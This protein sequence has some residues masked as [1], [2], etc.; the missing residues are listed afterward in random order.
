MSTEVAPVNRADSGFRLAWVVMFGAPLLWAILTLVHPSGEGEISA[1]LQ[2]EVGRWLFVHVAQVVLAPFLALAVWLLLRGIES[3]AATIS[4]VALVFWLVFFSTYDALAG[5]ASGVLVRQANSV[6]GEERA[7]FS[8]AADVLFDS[9]I[10]GNIS[11]FGV[12]AAVTWVIVAIAAA[13]ALRGAG[14]NWLTTAA[15]ALSALFAFH[16]G[17]PAFIGLIALLVAAFLWERRRA[18]SPVAPP[19]AAPAP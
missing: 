3:L 2:D 6:S 16:A 7:S 9:H 12:V 15:A 5:I 17:Y 13:V 8:E 19:A 18:Q 1:A 4:R 10:G 11:W 14:A